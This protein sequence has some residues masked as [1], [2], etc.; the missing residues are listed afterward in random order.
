[1]SFA[2]LFH[3]LEQILDSVYTVWYNSIKMRKDT[4]TKERGMTRK[5]AQITRIKRMQALLKK[6]KADYN[7]NDKALIRQVIEK[8]I[9]E[10]AE[11]E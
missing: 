9:A 10:D 11:I 8:H 5:Q 7:D 1:M 2:P 3:Y 6:D 4:E